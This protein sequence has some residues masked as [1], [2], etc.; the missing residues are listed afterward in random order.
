MAYSLA[1]STTVLS[2]VVMWSLETAA[3]S[4]TDYG[5]SCGSCTLD[6]V[7]SIIREEFRDVKNLV[8][9]NQISRVELA[10]KQALVSALVR[11]YSPINRPTLS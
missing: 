11:E 7:A 5:K 10:S 6:E 8:S 4:A 1:V 3:E 9:T 2:V